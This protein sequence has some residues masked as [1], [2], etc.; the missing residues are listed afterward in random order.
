MI[1]ILIL[2]LMLVG[3]VVFIVM[4]VKRDHQHFNI[5]YQQ[6]KVGQN[7][8]GSLDDNL[9]DNEHITL[10]TEVTS[11]GFATIFTDNQMN[12]ASVV[13]SEELEESI[14][15]L[16]S[17]Y[18]MGAIDMIGKQKNCTEYE[19]RSMV[20][21]ILFSN[22]NISSLC[23]SNYYASDSKTT[24]EHRSVMHIGAIAAKLW[25][26]EEKVPEGFTLK[27]QLQLYDLVV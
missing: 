7:K 25:L 23:I 14:K 6:A 1:E 15:N 16:V 12:S 3:G 13:L 8:Y 21:R 2:L 9:D 10:K 22:L 4:L 26:R 11:E 19:C 5:L 27:S 17:M 18:L 20:E 24:D